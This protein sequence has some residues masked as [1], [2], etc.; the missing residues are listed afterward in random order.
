MPRPKYPS[1]I[2]RNE[3]RCPP[4]FRVHTS[5]QNHPKMVKVMS[6]DRLLAA[7]LRLGMLCRDRGATETE[8]WIAL[9]PRDMCRV[10][11]CE[12]LGKARSTL[13]L[14]TFYLNWDLRLDGAVTLIHFRNFAEKQ[15]LTPRKKRSFAE[16]APPKKRSSPPSLSLTLLEESPIVPLRENGESEASPETAQRR[17]DPSNGNGATKDRETGQGTARSLEPERRPPPKLRGRVY[18]SPSGKVAMVNGSPVN[19][20]DGAAITTGSVEWQD[21]SGRW[22]LV[23]GGRWFTSIDE[24]E[25]AK[26]AGIDEAESR[27]G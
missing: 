13:A 15:G 2:E 24:A 8:D 9:T 25:L 23:R 1:D 5:I 10:S 22:S 19:W 18:L 21:N 4:H 26:L 27:E 20:L 17:H 11:N 6:D 7:W 16:H 12:R 14:L 3:A